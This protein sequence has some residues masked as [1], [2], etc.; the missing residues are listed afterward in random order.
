MSLEKKRQN[1]CFGYVN[2]FVWVSEWADNSFESEQ[3]QTIPE[4]ISF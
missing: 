4:F 1:Y 2:L 3:L